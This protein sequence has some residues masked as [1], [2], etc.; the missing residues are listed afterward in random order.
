MNVEFQWAGLFILEYCICLQMARAIQNH[1]TLLGVTTK[2]FVNQIV[3]K[4]IT[5]A[6]NKT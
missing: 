3:K 1:L 2:S 4:I 6:M 5:I